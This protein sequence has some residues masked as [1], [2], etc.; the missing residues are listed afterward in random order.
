[1]KISTRERRFLIGGGLAVLAILAGVYVVEP[2]V[3]TQQRMRDEVHAQSALL[4][5][6]QLLASEKA[7]YQRKVEALRAQL[8]QA[9]S[10]L[11]QGEKLPVVAADVQGLLHALAQEAGITIVRENVRPPKKVDAFTE[12][13][14]EL[15]VQGEIKNIRDFLY[16]IQTAPKLVT[17][18][19]LVIRAV[20]SRGATALAADLV[21][22]GHILN[23]EDKG[24]AAPPTA[25]KTKGRPR[26]ERA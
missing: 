20:P 10:L 9:D 25:G 24:P 23:G 11:F 5:K 22:T 18:P 2:F 12:V 16:K 6:H 15:S 3:T 14:V 21:V 26:L 19:K 7:R 1:M 8:Q 4:A 13:A 17:T